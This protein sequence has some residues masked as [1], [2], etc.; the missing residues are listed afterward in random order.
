[1]KKIFNLNWFFVHPNYDIYLSPFFANRLVNERHYDQ[2]ASTFRMIFIGSIVFKEYG[3]SRDQLK[4]SL[5]LLYYECIAPKRVTIL[6]GPS[7]R[8]CLR[9][10]QPL[11]KKCRSD[12][13]PLTILCSIWPTWDLSRLDLPLLRRMHY[14]W[15]NWPVL[16]TGMDIR[17]DF[18]VYL[19]LHCLA[20][21]R[22]V[23]GPT[24]SGPNPKTNLRPKSCPKKPES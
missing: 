22:V 4:F 6:R 10:I 14:R 19:R 16:A 20:Y 24:S 21:S 3:T 5:Y 15:T 7:P 8:H 1:M 13:E 23:N 17:I 9:A 18:A 2:K 12:G 11:S